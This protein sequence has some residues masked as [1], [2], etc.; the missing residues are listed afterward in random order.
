MNLVLVNKESTKNL[1]ARI[2]LPQPISSATL[3]QLTQHSD[4]AA[5]PNAAALTGVT[6]QGAA[7]GHDGTFEPGTAYSLAVSG[8]QLSCYVPALSAVLI[9]IT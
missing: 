5:A 8:T 7:I 3:Q 6:L 2:E 1:D 9:Q 4:G